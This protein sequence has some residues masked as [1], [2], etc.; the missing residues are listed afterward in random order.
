M[1]VVSIIMLTFAFFGGIDRIIG[2]KIGIGKEFEKGILLLGQ[3][4]LSM[5]GMIIIAPVLAELLSP[6]F[7]FLYN[8]EKRF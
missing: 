8:Y 4:V 5:M 3:L 7:S 2:N 1:N 6:F